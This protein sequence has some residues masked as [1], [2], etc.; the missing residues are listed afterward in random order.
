M[1]VLLLLV[2]FIAAP[3]GVPVHGPVPGTPEAVG[4]FVK[5]SD[6]TRLRWDNLVFR[7]LE[8]GSAITH[9]LKGCV[10]KGLRHAE[11]CRSG[12]DWKAAPETTALHGKG[13]VLRMI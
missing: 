13:E 10:G 12:T 2:L 3:S 5:I 6:A 9:E 7:Q 4:P 8:F 11:W 1:K